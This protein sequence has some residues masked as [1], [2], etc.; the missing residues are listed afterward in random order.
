MVRYSG[1]HRSYDWEGG[2]YIIRDV[3]KHDPTRPT[4]EWLLRCEYKVQ[5][6]G[7]DV[8][9]HTYEGVEFSQIE[10]YEKIALNG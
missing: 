10:P 6:E 4:K 3:W 8:W 9:L 5:R 1:D 2:R 7:K